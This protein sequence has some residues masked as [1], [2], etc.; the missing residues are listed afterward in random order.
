MFTKFSLISLAFLVLTAIPVET[1]EARNVSR[2]NPYRSFNISGRNYGSLRWEQQNRKRVV[3]KK[4]IRTQ[5][6]RRR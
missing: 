2:Q 4:R 3:V 5:R 6:W 1:V